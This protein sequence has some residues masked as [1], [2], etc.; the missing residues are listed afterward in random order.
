MGNIT[1][2][3]YK[4]FLFILGLILAGIDV[5]SVTPASAQG[6]DRSEF[7]AALARNDL[8]AI[9]RIIKLQE[10]LENQATVNQSGRGIIADPSHQPS[11]PVSS[12]DMI[13][14]VSRTL[15]DLDYSTFSR[16]LAGTVVRHVQGARTVRRRLMPSGQTD[17]LKLNV[18]SAGT[19]SIVIS[20]RYQNARYR[21][22]LRDDRGDILCDSERPQFKQSCTWNSFGAASYTLQITSLGPLQS[23]L[24]IVLT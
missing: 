16:G 7:E 2:F 3:D 15:P 10:E 12:A 17:T 22:T 23:T 9:L 1:G 24:E 8:D 19:F 21:M 14:K 18:R 11:A 6:I 20:S 13:E 5:W 4:P